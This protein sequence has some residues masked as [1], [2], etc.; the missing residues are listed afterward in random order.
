VT[1]SDLS[2]GKHC[3]FDTSGTAEA[4]SL[5]MPVALTFGALRDSSFWSRWF[6]FDFAIMYSLNEVDGFV[7]LNWFKIDKEQ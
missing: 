5:R 3:A 2:L 4:A 6:K 1:L 7:I